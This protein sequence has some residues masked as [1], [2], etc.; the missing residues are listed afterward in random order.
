MVILWRK[1]SDNA[2]NV[3][4]LVIFSNGLFYFERIGLSNEMWSAYY[5]F[6]YKTPMDSPKTAFC[7]ARFN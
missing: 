5:F 1:Y 2:L 4:C 7:Q 6:G 3:A